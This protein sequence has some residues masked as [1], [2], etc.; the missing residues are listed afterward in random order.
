MKKFLIIALLAAVISAVAF[1]G[2]TDSG[3]NNS[4]D[5]ITISG[6][7]ALYP[8]MIAWSEEYNKINPE[9]GDC[10]EIRSLNSNKNLRQ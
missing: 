3:N 8:M 4:Q 2:C 5:K 7:F 10:L 9:A 6:A 1:T